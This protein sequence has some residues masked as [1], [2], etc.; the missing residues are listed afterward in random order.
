MYLLKAATSPAGAGEV[1]RPVVLPFLCPAG[2]V[3][4][5]HVKVGSPGNGLTLHILVFILHLSPWMKYVTGPA[6]YRVCMQLSS[7]FFFIAV[8]SLCAACGFVIKKI[9]L[10]SFFLSSV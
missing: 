10:F 6:T 8:V 2:C 5:Q 7:G 9:H 1:A 3:V 4:S